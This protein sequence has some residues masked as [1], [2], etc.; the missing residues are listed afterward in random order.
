MR[1]GAVERSPSIQISLFAA[2]LRPDLHVLACREWIGR[3]I[4]PVFIPRHRHHHDGLQSE[5]GSIGKLVGDVVDFTRCIW[6]V[7]DAAQEL[8]M[9]CVGVVKNFE[10]IDAVVRPAGVA[11]WLACVIV[12]PT[13]LNSRRQ[14]SAVEKQDR[15]ERKHA[16]GYQQDSSPSHVRLNRGLLSFSLSLKSSHDR[17]QSGA[18][19]RIDRAA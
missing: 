13:Y 14:G 18:L 16:G 6:G 4:R 12:G 5:W 7:R 2:G 10:M 8:R 17:V 11:G 9:F 1:S 15:Y 19:R 3:A